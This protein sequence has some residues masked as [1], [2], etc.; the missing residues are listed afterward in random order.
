MM[1]ANDTELQKAATTAAL[2]QWWRGLTRPERL[3]AC[4]DPGY[5]TA[6]NRLLAGRIAEAFAGDV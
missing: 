4:L 1:I 2:E 5:R 6:C 3:A